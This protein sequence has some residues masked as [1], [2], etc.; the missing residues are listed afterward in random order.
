MNA[1]FIYW[2]G[3]LGFTQ[4]K[5]FFNLFELP[6]TTIPSKDNPIIHALYTLVEEKE[7]YKDPKMTLAQTAMLLA[8]SPKKLSE[9][10]NEHLK[11]NFSEFLNVH[12]VEKVKTLLTSPETEKYTLLAL[13]E[14]A[15][16]RTKSSFN[17]TFKRLTGITPSE[18][19]KQY[20]SVQ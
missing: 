3:Y 7:I 9:H 13:G 20:K 8:I 18:Y 2:I 4:F 12:R 10:I 6:K 11:M 15:G 14:I 5:S 17:T 19:R 1:I 16:F